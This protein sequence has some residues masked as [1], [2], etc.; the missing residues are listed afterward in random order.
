MLT[1]IWGVNGF[2][3]LDLMPSEYRFS[4]QYFVEH[5]MAPLVQTVFPQGRT[6][7]T[8]R[9]NVHLDNCRVHFL[10]VMEQVS[11][12]NQLLQVPHPSYGPHL[13]P[14]DFWLFGCVKTG[15]A[16]RNFAEPE[17]LL[18][19]VREFLEGIPGRN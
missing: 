1:A 14:S 3:L 15:L 2:Y 13:A 10:K 4:A 5:V 6:R 18:E 11:I 16:G 8:H 9:L 12:E 17:E 7:Y 19:G